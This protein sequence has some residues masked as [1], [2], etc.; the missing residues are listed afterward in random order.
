MLISILSTQQSDNAIK[1]LQKNK[2]YYSKYLNIRTI[3]TVSDKFYRIIQELSTDYCNQI[4][5][6]QTEFYVK[7]KQLCCL[8]E[9]LK[10][11]FRTLY[12]VSETKY[13]FE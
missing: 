8:F 2:F 3:F 7:Y 6:Y 11:G 9:N 1:Q 4:Q 12:W 10:S 5:L 13:A